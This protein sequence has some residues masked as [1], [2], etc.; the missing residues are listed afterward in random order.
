MSLK[1]LDLSPATLAKFL[2]RN[3]RTLGATKPDTDAKA[4]SK[5]LV[6]YSA[7]SIHDLL[8]KNQILFPDLVEKT[9]DIYGDEDST[10]GDRIRLIEFWASLNVI[11]AIQDPELLKEID[12]KKTTRTSVDPFQ[13]G[14]FKLASSG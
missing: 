11:G 8:K 3:P 2:G 7:R 10:P 14:K 6:Q 1:N 5:L 12:V 9:L 13:A 4:A